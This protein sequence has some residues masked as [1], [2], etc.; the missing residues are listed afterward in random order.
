MDKRIRKRLGSEFAGWIAAGVLLGSIGAIGG[1]ATPSSA[2]PILSLDLDPG[3]PDIQTSAVIG[4]GDSIS[5]DVLIASV[6]AAEP[7]N[8][9]QLEIVFEG[10]V[11][12]VS[13]AAFGDF[14]VGPVQPL[15]N[16]LGADRVSLAAV[17][18]GPGAAFGA[19]RLASLTLVGVGAGTTSLAI[20]NAVLS[21]PFGVAIDGASL[22]TA[23]LRVVAEP[24]T[25]TL[26]V[27]GLA[28]ASL[29]R[30]RRSGP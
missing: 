18:L 9:F 4:A 7:L 14:L 12:A 24:A 21:R 5:I 20:E 27:L 2:M 11:A 23:S 30:V 17:T 25:L 10:L 26:L 13:M 15:Q 29:G 19:G 8:A 1:L 28:T 3:T 16:V 22:E 6:E